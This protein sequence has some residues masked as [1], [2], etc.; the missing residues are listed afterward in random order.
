M[1]LALLNMV[2]RVHRQTERK[3]KPSLGR[4]CVCVCKCTRVN[5]VN[6]VNVMRRHVI[7]VLSSSVQKVVEVLMIWMSSHIILS[8]PLHSRR[9]SKYLKSGNRRHCTSTSCKEPHCMISSC[10]AS[11]PRPTSSPNMR[12]LIRPTNALSPCA[13]SC[14]F[15]KVHLTTY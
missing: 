13:A 2:L 1:E 10:S 5:L 15:P 12:S 4:L 7:S 11:V 8:D 9:Y 14:V 6:I 3:I